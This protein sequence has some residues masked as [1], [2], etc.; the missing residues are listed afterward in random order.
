[1]DSSSGAG[2]A[3]I[4]TAPESQRGTPGLS[5]SDLVIK[6][7]GVIG[8]GDAFCK[9]GGFAVVAGSNGVLIV[10]IFNRGGCIPKLETFV[11]NGGWRSHRPRIVDPHW[12]QPIFAVL[13]GDAFR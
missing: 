1:V 11:V 7:E 8:A 3:T 12:A 6:Y 4:A 13:L 9:L 2:A 10:E 5:L